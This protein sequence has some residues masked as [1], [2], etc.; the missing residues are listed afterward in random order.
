MKAEDGPASRNELHE[1]VV[2]RTF[3]YDNEAKCEQH[4]GTFLRNIKAASEAPG[5]GFA[6]IKVFS[7]SLP[8]IFGRQR[9]HMGVEMQICR[10][11]GRRCS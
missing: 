5:Q 8:S 9:W 6:A 3:D 2:A 7:F 11:C 10:S 1:S 4:T